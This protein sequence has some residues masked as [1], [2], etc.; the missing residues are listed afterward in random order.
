MTKYK[1]L[2]KKR[3]KDPHTSQ[4]KERIIRKSDSS[5]FF[6]VDS[7]P[8][9]ESPSPA[10]KLQAPYRELIDLHTHILPRLDDGA[11]NINQAI[12]MARLA[13]NDGIRTVVATPHYYESKGRGLMGKRLDAMSALRTALAEEDIHLELLQGFEV[14]ATHSL[15][16]R[17]SLGPLALAGSQWILLEMPYIYGD[18]FEAVFADALDEGLLPL[19][20]HP[21]RYPY[22]TT[23][24]RALEGFV[25]KG[26]WAQLS[27]AAL[28]GDSGQEEQQWCLRALDLGLAHVVAS[29][30][31]NNS[32]RPPRMQAAIA[33]VQEA[34]GEEKCYEIFELNPARILGRRL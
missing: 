9:N 23:D 8:T 25:E 13:R 28:A 3:S 19:I 5:A 16:N 30:M 31:H 18:E 20:A 33:V 17:R 34:L 32:N 6:A 4:A 2:H 7:S 1:R 22:F 14:S 10:P 29:D 27:A 24:F 11:R 26:A 15:L 12:F 21:E